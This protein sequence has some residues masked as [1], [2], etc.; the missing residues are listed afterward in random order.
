MGGGE[1]SWVRWRLFA[2]DRDIIESAWGNLV[3][4]EDNVGGGGGGLLLYVKM[5]SNRY[6]TEDI[7]NKTKQVIYNKAFT[8]NMSYWMKR[9]LLI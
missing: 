6:W 3:Q 7:S 8:E 2:S 4:V 5:Y 9:V 1:M